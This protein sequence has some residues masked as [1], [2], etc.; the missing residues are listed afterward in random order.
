MKQIELRL[1]A[2]LASA[3]LFLYGA[4]TANLPANGAIV[5]YQ[6]GEQGPNHRVWQKVL[7][8]TDARGNIVLSTNRA[9]VEVATGLNF[10][11][12]ATG[13]WLPSKEEIEAYPGGAIAQCSGSP[14]TFLD[15]NPTT[16]LIYNDFNSIIPGRYMFQF[17]N[18]I[19]LGHP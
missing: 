2:L 3:P 18:G 1:I 19:P 10:K 5:G 16:G 13:K 7:R 17:R 6:I 14:G 15:S 9:F 8:V 4:P 12:P 11:D